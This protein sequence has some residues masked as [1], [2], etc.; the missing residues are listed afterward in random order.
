MIQAVVGKCWDSYFG[1][2]DLNLPGVY[3]FFLDNSGNE[4][5]EKEEIFDHYFNFI[6]D[7]NTQEEIGIDLKSG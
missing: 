1:V 4:G 2:S 3:Y 6:A 5:K 7:T